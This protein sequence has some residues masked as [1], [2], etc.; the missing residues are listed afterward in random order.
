M[1]FKDGNIPSNG[2]KLTLALFTLIGAVFAIK[3]LLFGFQ[4]SQLHN[5]LLIV[6]TLIFFIRLVISLFVFIKRKVSWFEGILV[7]TLYGI[8]IVGFSDWG[9]QTGSTNLFWDI[10]GFVLFCAG[11]FINSVSD[12]QR[13]VWKLKSENQGHIYTLG[14]FRY[15]MHINYFGDTIMLT[16]FAIVTQNAMSFLPVLAI[17]LNLILLQIPLLDAHLK[18]K[19]GI[20]FEAYESKTKKF[21]PFIY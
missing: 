3:N 1:T 8:M 11:S 10:G 17:A 16:G 13:H 4:D 2:A 12:Y 21:I 7:G 18:N 6:C 5:G 9:T 14:L 19:Y 20:E 15:A